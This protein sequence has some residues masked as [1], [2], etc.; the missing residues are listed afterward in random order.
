[1][2][3][4]LDARTTA[5]MCKLVFSP[6]RQEGRLHHLLDHLVGDREEGRRHLDPELFRGLD[7]DDQLVLGRRLNWKVGGLL[8]FENPVDVT[9][10]AYV[11]IN[12]C[13]SVRKKPAALGEI[14]E[15]VDRRQLVSRCKRDDEVSMRC[16]R[17]ASCNDHTSLRGA[18]EF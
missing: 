15:R 4:H 17:R 5:F 18:G 3:M 10:C 6:S 7:I 11:G 12:G 9:C 2:W 13:W 8:A 16:P 14:A 1:M